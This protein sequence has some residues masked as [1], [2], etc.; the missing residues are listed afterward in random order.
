MPKFFKVYVEQEM[1]DVVT[2]LSRL[3]SR[4]VAA[5]IR[6]VLDRENFEIELE[7]ARSAEAHRLALLQQSAVQRQSQTDWV[8]SQQPGPGDGHGGKA[9]EH[10][11]RR[12][13]RRAGPSVRGRASRP[14]KPQGKRK[15]GGR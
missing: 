3:T 11:E 8:A 13:P 2:E 10:S 6:D 4:P 9:S 12:A 1:F 14:V 15:R 5:I 7:R